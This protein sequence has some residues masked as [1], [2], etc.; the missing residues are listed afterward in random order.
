MLLS[1]RPLR[2]SVLLGCATTRGSSLPLTMYAAVV[3]LYV[4]LH[5]NEC[6]ALRGT[7]TTVRSY[8]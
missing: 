8:V 7:N 4:A 1:C 6:V 2:V 3:R 5:S